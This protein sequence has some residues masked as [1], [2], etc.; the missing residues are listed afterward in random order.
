VPKKKHRRPTK[1]KRGHQ[2]PPARRPAQ[3]EDQ[4]DH[5]LDDLEQAVAADHPLA[6]L[7]FASAMLNALDPRNENPFAP[8]EPS[9]LPPLPGLLSSLTRAGPHPVAL[10]WALAHLVDDDLL[11]ARVVREIGSRAFLLPAWMRHLDRVEAVAAEQV[12]DVLR[13]SFSVVIHARLAGFNLTAV[14]LID[15]NLGTVVKD[16]FFIAETLEGFDTLWVEHADPEQTSL[17][18]L[19]LADA[20]A[21]VAEAVRVGAMTFPPTE[22]EH[23]PGTRPLLEWF[24]RHLPAG[25][26][27]FVRPEWSEADQSQL[28]E[29]FVTGPYGEGLPSDARAI[30]DDLLWYRTGYGYGDPLRWG[31]TAVEILLLDWYPRKIVADSAYLAAMPAVLHAFVRFAHAEAGLDEALTTLTLAA[32]D[33]FQDEYRALVRRPRRQGPEALLETMG[34]LDPLEDDPIEE[35]NL[36]QMMR[37]LLADQVGG[38]AELDALTAE[39]LPDEPF[40]WDGLPPELRG[41]AAAVLQ[42]CDDCCVRLFDLE[43][44]TAVRRLL[45]DV[46]VAKPRIFS[47]RGS[48]TTAAAALC[49]LVGRA[50]ESLGY[51]GTVSVQ[52]LARHF[53]LSATPSTRAT[54]MRQAIGA[55]HNHWPGSL[56]AARYLT[57]DHRAR[58]I[59]LRDEGPGA[60]PN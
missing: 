60:L 19:S 47:G 48:P 22:S 5:L 14:T 20:R 34:V 29:R 12:T 4:S 26:T 15:F 52:E 40:G 24:L 53:G 42:L 50:N 51:P 6:L 37:H 55:D 45:H 9:E 30:A 39:P 56:G 11:R 13:D 25:G 10:A 36:D 31:P 16:N 54:T 3:S 58:L 35:H 49:W 33:E 59:A 43:H 23:W 1:P 44:R 38:E 32:V 41:P 17:E 8:S 46:A 7:G 18:P 28:S 27:G 21:R 2:H 57:A